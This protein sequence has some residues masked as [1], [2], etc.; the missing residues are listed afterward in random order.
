MDFVLILLIGKAAGYLVVWHIT[1][2]K[3]IEPDFDGGSGPTQSINRRSRADPLLELDVG[4]L[5]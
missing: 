2:N 1:V 4:A 3:C 5:A